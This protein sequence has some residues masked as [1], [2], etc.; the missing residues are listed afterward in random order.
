MISVLEVDLRALC[1]LGAEIPVSATFL[2]STPLFSVD[3]RGV[4]CACPVCSHTI[5]RLPFPAILSPR[6]S[7]DER[8]KRAYTMESLLGAV[9]VH[10]AAYE[11]WIAAEELRSRCSE[12]I[13]AQDERRAQITNKEMERDAIRR[14]AV[15][16]ENELWKVVAEGEE[17]MAQVRALNEKIQHRTAIIDRRRKDLEASRE[18]LARGKSEL[19]EKLRP[20]LQ[21][22]LHR[23]LRRRRSLAL[24]AADVYPIQPSPGDPLV[25]EI[26]GLRLPNSSYEGYPLDTIS[27]ALG[28]ATHL[29]VLLGRALDVPLR[30]P[31]KPMGSR[32]TVRDVSGRWTT[33]GDEFPLYGQGVDAF[34][35]DYGVLLLNK[36]VE[37]IANHLGI[38]VADLRNTLPNLH[39]VVNR[40]RED[41]DADEDTGAD[42]EER[43]QRT[44]VRQNTARRRDTSALPAELSL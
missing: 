25:Y 4:F 39:A 36:N 26:A 42:D 40:L 30:Y 6:N 10:S 38:F 33:P 20:S 41:A 2:P 17:A 28:H 21:P 9:S 22:L 27:I 44:L 43:N 1:Y 32:A 34:R 24:A 31:L 29:A 12:A 15:S 11:S 14:A 7:S 35:F 37:Q 19:K 5:S 18:R 3:R 16:A 8:P 23:E 13:M